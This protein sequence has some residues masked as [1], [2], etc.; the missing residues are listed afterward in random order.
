MSLDR[1][2]ALCTGKVISRKEEGGWEG[3]KEETD[4]VASGVSYLKYPNNFIPIN[5]PL[6]DASHLLHGTSEVSTSLTMLGLVAEY[7]YI[8]S[9][10]ICC[11]MKRVL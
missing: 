11:L 7:M 4:L 1:L 9:G 5:L 8:F 2:A 3:R 10:E 6:A